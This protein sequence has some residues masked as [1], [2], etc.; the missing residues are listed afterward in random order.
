KGEKIRIFS[1]NINSKV[2]E[3]ALIAAHARGVSVRILM[4]NGLA[5]GQDDRG[6]YAKL[7]H[8]LAQRQSTRRP[9]MTSWVRTCVNSCRGQG[10]AAHSKF[11][12]FSRVY[13]RTN[14]VMVGSPNLTSAASNNQWNDLVTLTDRP[15]LY[16]K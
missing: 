3:N 12:V 16:A 7:K 14:V 9:D 2:F 5:E 1:W 13:Q 6:S 8:A 11:L 15:G 10:G 4:S